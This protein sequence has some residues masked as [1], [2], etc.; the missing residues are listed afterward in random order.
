[1]HE[2]ALLAYGVEGRFLCGLQYDWGY[3][4]SN[5]PTSNGFLIAFE[6]RFA[7]SSTD[8]VLLFMEGIHFVETESLGVILLAPL[9]SPA[10]ASRCASSVN[11][12]PASASAAASAAGHRWHSQARS[13]G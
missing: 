10:T 1:M 12:D 6:Q 11:T 8:L 3:I 13:R 7:P 4:T 2:R 9:V 5:H